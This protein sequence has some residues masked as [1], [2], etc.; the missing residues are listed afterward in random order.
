MPPCARA[1]TA[2][3]DAFEPRNATDR[4]FYPRDKLKRIL[5]RDRVVEVLD[6]ACENCRQHREDLKLVDQP[7]DCVDAILRSAVSLFALLISINAAPFVVCFV[8]RQVNDQNISHF[9]EDIPDDIG[10]SY[11]NFFHRRRRE[12]SR[13]IARQFRLHLFQFAIPTLT[14]GQYHIFGERTI[15]PFVEQVRIGRTEEDGTVVNEGAYGTVYACK[16]WGAYNKLSVSS[17]LS[18]S[19]KANVDTILTS[20]RTL[21]VLNGSSGRSWTCQRDYSIPRSETWKW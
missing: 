3:F 17:L 15:L 10:E 12:D 9:G 6:C 2:I 4:C 11:W 16:I 20:E 13:V 18:L 21:E 8:A 5:H 19:K 14:R 7:S 1:Q